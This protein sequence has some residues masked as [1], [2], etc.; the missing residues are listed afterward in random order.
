M[1]PVGQ[2]RDGGTNTKKSLKKVFVVQGEQSAVTALADKIKN[3]LDIEAVIPKAAE[4]F[5]L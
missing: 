5:D 1:P 4:S 2:Y 3:D